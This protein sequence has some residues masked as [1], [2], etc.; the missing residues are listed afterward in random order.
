MTILHKKKG[1]I[2]KNNS[3]NIKILTPYLK[4]NVIKFIKIEDK[5][6]T[7]CLNYVNNKPV[8]NNIVNLHKSSNK[9]LISL[10]TLKKINN[11][12]NWIFLISTDKGILNS[13]EAVKNNRG[14]LLLAKI[15]N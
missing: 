14:G 7:V 6:I 3:T 9:K 1:F 8:F 12:H 13:Y 10:K 5:R 11:K 2:I 4:I 15:W